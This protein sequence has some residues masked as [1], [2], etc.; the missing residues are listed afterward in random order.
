MFELELHPSLPKGK[1]H[2]GWLAGL[3]TD[4]PDENTRDAILAAPR[5][6]SRL[7]EMLMAGVEGPGVDDDACAPSEP[8]SWLAARLNDDL[9][10]RVGQIWLAPVLARRLLDRGER[11]ALGI[12]GRSV[13]RL[14]LRYQV[15]NLPKRSA[16]V[17]DYRQD[18]VTC[19]A[20]WLCQSPEP[21]ARRLLLCL[22]PDL[23]SN[24]E[25]DNARAAFTET[26]LNDPD[27][28]EG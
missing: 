27:F 16:S 13:L 14:I 19:I 5:F 23:P 15:H 8:L 7:G 9:F 11:C 17:C 4:I 18:G 12:E 10:S 22:T 24:P 21:A 3:L 26:L 2:L 1:V 28:V 6:A 20:A 25:E